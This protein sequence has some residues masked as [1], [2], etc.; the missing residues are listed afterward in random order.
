MKKFLSQI[1]AGVLGIWIADFFIP[2]VKIDLLS[3]SNFFGIPLNSAWQIIV[4]LGIV[5]GLLNYFIKPIIKTITLPL[6]IITLG[7]FS[8]VINMGIIWI[9]DYTFREITI[10]W[11]WPLFW[12]TV[13]ISFLNIAIP[14]LL[15]KDEY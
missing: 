14:K 15:I 10:A 12:T 8:I 3:N 1:I 11:L 4:L 13:I 9:L 7:L 6:R 2:G 5:L